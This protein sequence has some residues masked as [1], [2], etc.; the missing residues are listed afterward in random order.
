MSNQY[1]QIDPK[2]NVIV[3]I[4]PLTKGT[5]IEVARESLMLKED[6]KQKHKFAL[7]DFAIGDEIYM[8]GVLIGKTVKAISAGCAITIDNVKH[9]SAEYKESSEK[10]TWTAPDISNFEGRTFNGFP[11]KDGKV[12]TANYWLVIPLTFCENRNV[13]VLEGALSEKLGYETKKDFAVDTDALIQQY[14]SGASP[15]EI[16]NTPIITTKEE[17][18][19]NRVFPNVDG[20]K[21]LKHDGGCGGIRQDSETLCKLLAGYISNPNVAGATVFSLGCQNA[22][23]EMLQDAIK[24]IAPDNDKPVHYLEQQQSESERQLI[25]EA[26]KHTFIGLVEANKLTRQ[27][28]PLSKLVLGLECGGSDGFSGISANPGLGYASDLLV[29][30][31]GS[32]VLSEFPE[33]NGVEQEIINRCETEQ[34][35]K[36]FYD[37]MRAYSAA[38]VAVGSGFENNPSPGNIKDGLIT[39]AMKSA[40]AAKKG[41]T[42]PVVQVLDYTEQVTKPG[43]N[44]LCTP[45]NDVES[46]TGLVGS[47]CNVVVFTTGLGTPTGN[48]IAPVLKMSSNTNL[49]ERMNDIIDINA[50]TVITG[51]DTIQT[52]GE[53]IL[54]HIIRVASGETPSKAVLHGNND[55]IPW[56][57]GV[58]L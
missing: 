45:G 5:F 52:M 51:E 44:L 47:G 37:L 19:K 39:D 43:L 4:Q 35:A 28:A 31:G 15:E 58:S 27:P 53:K 1:T 23:I 3:A 25:E 56:K 33:L 29:A 16:F 24:A 40:G 20:I 46:T 26:V 54:D 10:F 30:L 17:M 8:Y 32:P 42:S 21:F 22:Q 11:R 48:P 55:F 13:D 49:Y 6:I 36:K 7:Y 18:S 57:R 41:G 12:G 50:G 38:A 14:R 9:A 2:D 34:D